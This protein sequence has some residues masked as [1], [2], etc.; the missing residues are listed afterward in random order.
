MPNVYP[1]AQPEVCKSL[2]T[3]MTTLTISAGRK[4]SPLARGGWVGEGYL[5]GSRAA[6]IIPMIYCFTA[7]CL[8]APSGKFFVSISHCSGVNETETA[9]QP[10][11]LAGLIIFSMSSAFVKGMS[12]PFFPS[13]PSTVLSF[14][15][16]ISASSAREVFDSA[17]HTLNR[18]LSITALY[19]PSNGEK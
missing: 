7:S 10:G 2:T 14:T 5:S 3:H 8:S 16:N 19:Y 6:L 15:P 4:K 9:M 13:Q 17:S 12:R 11:S 18:V 1:T